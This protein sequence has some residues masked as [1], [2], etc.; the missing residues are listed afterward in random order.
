M[1][2]YKLTKHKKYECSTLGNVRNIQTNRILKPQLNGSNYFYI[3][4]DKKKIKIHRLVVE[5]FIGSIPKGMVVNHLNGIKTDNRIENLQICSQFENTKHA[6]EL[7]FIKSTKNT[8]RFTKTFI[9]KL[10]NSEH[11]NNA[12][13]FY[14]TLIN[15]IFTTKL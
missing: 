7:G 11:W 9:T 6:I 2:I 14:K 13:S 1:E 4:D 15:H 5:T 3:T 8:S 10:Y 12:E